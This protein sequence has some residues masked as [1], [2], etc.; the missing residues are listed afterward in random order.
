[1]IEP[2]V[3]GEVRGA[4]WVVEGVYI[5]QSPRAMVETLGFALNEMS[6]QDVEPKVT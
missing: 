4:R 2:R 1:M 3:G 6:Q 5:A